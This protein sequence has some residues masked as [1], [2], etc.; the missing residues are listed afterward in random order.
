MRAAGALT[1]APAAPSLPGV[2]TVVTGSVALGCTTA[3]P[4]P[5]APAPA[6][7]F[8]VPAHAA[9]INASAVT[10]HNFLFI[11]FIA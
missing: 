10:A 3:P 11:I 2:V 8:L 4:L 6:A 7:G 9:S 1:P 5:P